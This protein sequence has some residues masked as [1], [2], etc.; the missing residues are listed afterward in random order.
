[1]TARSRS[2]S[3]AMEYK[4][5]VPYDFNLS[6]K[7][8][9]IA[10]LS[11]LL[12]LHAF[13]MAA[14]LS[15]SDVIQIKSDMTLIQ[16]GFET[17]NAEAIFSLTHPSAYK[18]VGG[19]EEFEKIVIQTLAKTRGMGA[20]YLN[21]DIGT[22]TQEYSAGEEEVCFVPT[23]SI[24]EIGGKKLKSMG[25]MIAIRKNGTHKW[26][27]LDGAALRKFP[28]LLYTL[29]PKLPNEIELPQNKVEM[30]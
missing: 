3:Y 21:R 15:E 28:D 12:F 7:M 18:L 11:L 8:K 1:M 4:N 14:S 10:I 26:K 16:N 5:L 25:F 23:T 24:L 22:P 13:S 17:G 19:K 9:K 29:I 20:K 30:L 6:K 2:L 27:Y